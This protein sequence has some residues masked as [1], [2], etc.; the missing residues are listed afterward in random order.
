MVQE[1]AGNFTR[2]DCEEGPSW[3][4]GKGRNTCTRKGAPMSHQD[5]KP[6]TCAAF[7][8]VRAVASLFRAWQ[9]VAQAMTESKR[10]HTCKGNCGA[11]CSLSV[12]M[13]CKRRIM[14]AYECSLEERVRRLIWLRNRSAD[15]C[16][17][18]IHR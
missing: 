3:G 7:A 8:V 9:I 10:L 12:A 13:P 17:D 4:T 14:G 16:L 11:P 15:C 2:N 6:S 18:S 5:R 1:I